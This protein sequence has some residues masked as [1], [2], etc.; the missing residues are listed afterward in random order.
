MKRIGV[1]I[2]IAVCVSFTPAQAADPVVE[3]CEM[4]G[5]VGGYGV[6]GSASDYIET[7]VEGLGLFGKI[8][9][10]NVFGTGINVQ[11][12]AYGEFVEAKDYFEPNDAKADSYGYVSHYYYRTDDFAAGLLS[13]LGQ[14]SD[15]I[16]VGNQSETMGVIGLDVHAYVDRL[17]LAGQFAYWS[18]LNDNDHIS[19]IK[20]AYQ[21]SGELRYF[22]TDNLK[23][24]GHLTYDWSANEGD[25]FPW[26]AI[27]YGAGAEYLFDAFPVSIFADYTRIEGKIGSDAIGF[28]HMDSDLF[29]AGLAIH[30]NSDSLISEDRNGP[31]FAD[32]KI[33]PLQN[34]LATAWQQI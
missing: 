7:D 26:E 20:E 6:L 14:V 1:G 28:D 10:C 3:T 29:R 21:A 4:S 9:F 22:A 27:S 23:L 32:P 19:Q 13:G 34:L 12:G 8:N 17:T 5:V 31:S 24:V 18:T 30:F 33:D 15:D 16:Y 2:A 25:E 11:S